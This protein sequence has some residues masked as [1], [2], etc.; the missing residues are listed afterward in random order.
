MPKSLLSDKIQI[1]RNSYYIFF[2][3]KWF[4]SYLREICVSHID[5]GKSGDII[6]LE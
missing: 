4:E 2:F 6:N 3:W 1:P 5:E